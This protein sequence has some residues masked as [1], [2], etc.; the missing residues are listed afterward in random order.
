MNKFI[1]SLVS[2]FLTFGLFS[3]STTYFQTVEEWHQKRINDLK[4]SNGWLN[5]EGLFWLKKGI[6]SFGKA[7][8][9]SIQVNQD[10]FPDYLGDYI[11]EGDSVVWV[12]QLG[13]NVKLNDQLI[14]DAQPHLIYASNEGK[15]HLTW[16]DFKWNI[17]KREDKIG[18]R[19]RNLA[20][21]NVT[22]FKGIERFPVDSQ[23]RVKAFL[24]A[25]E[26]NFLMI[27]N[28]L[29]QITATKNAGR[30]LFSWDG[31]EYGLDV[32]DEGGKTLFVTFA[33][34]S[35]GQT[36]YGAGRFIDVD[37]PDES[38]YTW[39]D[40]NFAY[41]PPCAFTEFATCPLPPPQN[42]L[43]FFINAGE[44]NYGHH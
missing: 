39:I 41:N 14:L 25:P 30:L 38:G 6:N 37:R 10:S 24:Q 23:W 35:S 11:Y 29:G 22:S 28:V 5:L 7:K 2:V 21:K 43:P 34:A 36:T 8:S 9:N 1:L 42:R 32:I 3:Q 18:I 44:K 33:D 40:F 27:T 15:I 19:F 13:Y 4:K 31:K 16:T 20:S 17:I 12:S 26:K